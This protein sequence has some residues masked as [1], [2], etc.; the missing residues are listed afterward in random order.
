MKKKME[1]PQ[2]ESLRRTNQILAKSASVAGTALD[3]VARLEKKMASKGKVPKKE[4]RKVPQRKVAKIVNIDRS[5]GSLAGS[6]F[7]DYLRTLARPFDVSDVFCPVSYNPSPSFI[8]TRARTTSTLLTTTVAA[9]TT[10]QIALFPGHLPSPGSASAAAVAAAG[11]AQAMDASSYHQYPLVV[12]A[13]TYS[14]GPMTTT[15]ASGTYSSIAG[16]ITTGLAANSCTN[17]TN[18]G[19]CQPLLWDN[20]LPYQADSTQGHS[21]WQLVSMGI[22]V[23]NITNDLYRGGTTV[24][25]QP[26]I[27][28]NFGPG[29][30]SLFE[31]FPTFHD[32][33]RCTGVELA[34][35]PRTADLAFWHTVDT[36]TAS[37]AVTV[38][39]GAGMYVWFNAPA[40]YAQTFSYEIVCNWQ[41]A[42][43]YLNTVGGPA[44]H[45]PGLKPPIEQTVAALL[46]SAPSAN[47][48]AEL[49]VQA[50]KATGLTAEGLA[51]KM[52]AMSLGAIKAA[53][54]GF[55]N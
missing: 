31:R 48:A 11:V 45:H 13:T 5:V 17:V 25:V 32:W 38:N 36:P 22:R 2:S 44:P 1:N 47:K 15:T 21:R 9:G 10:S 55:A 3:R 29:S 41:L 7:L 42:G 16:V 37:S 27:A 46:N 35:I 4:K 28:F 14:V 18:G 53:A 50:L 20:G 8:Q 51:S 30:Q 6:P 12:N 24:S 39:I 34:W 26:N 33:G 49:G 54:A 43:T 52:T 40:D 23:Q 19:T